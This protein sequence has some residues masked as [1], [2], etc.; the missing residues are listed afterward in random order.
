V[1]KEI[2]PNEKRILVQESRTQYTYDHLFV[3][4]GC[5][6]FYPINEDEGIFTLRSE[7]D[8]ADLIEKLELAKNQRLLVVGGGYTGVEVASATVGWKKTGHLSSVT[9]V[10]TSSFII[11]FRRFRSG[12]IIPL[13]PFSPQVNKNP[14]LLQNIFSE[15]A[16]LLGDYI[17]SELTERGLTV[18]HNCLIRQ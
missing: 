9:L 14:H 16:G 11:R 13:L 15:E 4:T 7:A 5:R 2:V 10:R 8:A 6:C 1:V 12:V 3:A 18:K 17:E